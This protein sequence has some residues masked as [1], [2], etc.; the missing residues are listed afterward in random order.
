MLE[1]FINCN[2]C[3]K[4]VPH[5]DEQSNNKEPHMCTLF[6]KKLYHKSN[7]LERH[8]KIHPCNECIKS[9]E[10]FLGSITQSS[11]EEVG[12]ALK[13]MVDDYRHSIQ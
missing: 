13:Q 5:E 7:S 1:D 4:C 8:S 3:E 9:T 12:S 11:P 2:Y 10:Q 6:N